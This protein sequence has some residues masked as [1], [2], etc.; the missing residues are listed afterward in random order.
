MKKL[1]ISICVIFV[2]LSIGAGYVTI[3]IIN[4]PQIRLFEGV[5][6]DSIDEIQIG[7]FGGTLVT[8]DNKQIS[9]IMNCLKSLKISKRSNNEVPNTTPDAEID[10]IDKN[11]L[12]TKVEIYGDVA[13]MY[14]KE[15][16]NY[17]I[18]TSI[19]SDLEDLCKK[20]K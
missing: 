1:I 3:K 10:L 2:I 6:T 11:G 16:H 8:K 9:E 17:T 5:D 15:E 19:Y 12:V 13:R 7:Y 4:R 20:Y 18:S 14:P